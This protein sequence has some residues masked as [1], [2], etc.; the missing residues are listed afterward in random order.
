M[1]RVPCFSWAICIQFIQYLIVLWI[2]LSLRVI[3][4][5]CKGIGGKSFVGNY[6]L[7]F[8]N[9]FLP[10]LVCFQCLFI[11]PDDCYEVEG[12]DQDSVGDSEDMDDSGDEAM[13]EPI[14][15]IEVEDGRYWLEMK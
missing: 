2:D 8:H 15:S 10:I 4:K 9:S 6:Y 11:F 13:G 14:E 5:S 12:A 1:S 7:Y 3:T